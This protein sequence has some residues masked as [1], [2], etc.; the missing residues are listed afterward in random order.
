MWRRFWT[1]HELPK[2]ACLLSLKHS[3]L[4][5]S[6]SKEVLKL[7]LLF[8]KYSVCL[9]AEIFNPIFLCNWK[10]TSRCLLHKGRS[11]NTLNIAYVLI[12]FKKN[13][14]QRVLKLVSYARKNKHYNANFI[15]GRSRFGFINVWRFN[16]LRKKML[17]I[18][19][20]FHL[21][22]WNSL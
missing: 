17:Q 15:K 3:F 4:I 10:R 21:F 12:V 18:N 13:N 8:W 5:F 22:F 9:I 6:F 16:V 1:F 11:I 19:F 14:Q 7:L 2:T 20:L